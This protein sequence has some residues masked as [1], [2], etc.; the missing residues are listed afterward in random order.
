MISFK[1]NFTNKSLLCTDTW[2]GGQ[3]EESIS[4]SIQC[5]TSKQIIN[6]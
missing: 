4:I 5:T 6:D 2:G 3:K 1:K